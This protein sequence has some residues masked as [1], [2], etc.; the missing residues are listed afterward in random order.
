MTTDV[1]LR[2]LTAVLAE[3]RRRDEMALQLYRPTP[4]Q[5]AFHR[6]TCRERIVRGGNRSGK[7]TAGALEF[8]HAATR[9]PILTNSGKEIPYKY[10]RR[11]LRLWCFGIDEDHIGDTI[12]TL[13]FKGGLFNVIDDLETGK[14]RVWNPNDPSDEARRKERRRSGPMIPPEMVKEF[15]WKDKRKRVFSKC[16]L[17][18]GTEIYAYPSGGDCPSGVP[19]DLIWIDEDIKYPEYVADWQGRL[20]DTKGRLIWT[21]FPWAR[22]DA[23][24]EMSERAQKLADQPEAAIRE[25]QLFMSENPYLEPDA[26][27]DALDGWA[28]AGNDVLA[29]RDRGEFPHDKVRMYPEF[30]KDVHGISEDFFPGDHEAAKVLFDNNGEPPEDWM[31]LLALDP[32]SARCAVVFAAVPPPELGNDIFIYDEIFLENSDAKSLA[33]EVQVRTHGR[34][35]HKFLIDEHAGRQTAM[36]FGVKIRQAYIDAFRARDIRCD[37]GTVFTPGSDDVKF[38]AEMVRQRLRIEDGNRFPKVFFWLPRT[39]RLQWE[40]LKYSRR[41]SHREYDDT[42]IPVNNDAMNCFEYIVAADIPYRKPRP[43]NRRPMVMQQWDA[44]ASFFSDRR[45]QEKHSV[46]MGAQTTR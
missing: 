23:L 39:Q 36:G 43:N 12:Y 6:G 4:K 7:S 29:A 45:P 11:P 15:A 37:S 41:L 18:N 42:P 1:A 9:L 8:A 10:P 33:K 27:K 3:E 34:S 31:R 2:D 40:F 21:A 28:A 17:K 16:V 14:P 25:W 24:V 5:E 46:V 32:G 20:I 38:R 19:V 26:K 22:N 44:L 30:R 13:L 35:F